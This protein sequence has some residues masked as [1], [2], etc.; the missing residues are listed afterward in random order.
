MGAQAK[1]AMAARPRGVGR[2]A[3]SAPI[4]NTTEATIYAE[5]ASVCPRSVAAPLDGAG[6]FDQ[7][8]R[9]DVGVG[10]R[11]RLA[12]FMRWPAATGSAP[13]SHMAYL[14]AVQSR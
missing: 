14:R 13:R 9:S 11:A 4:D 8:G 5:D 10:E 3:A 1:S 7:L 6:D 2:A 12:N